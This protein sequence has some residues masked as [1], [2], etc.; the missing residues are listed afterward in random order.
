MRNVPVGAGYVA[1]KTKAL[2]PL[3]IIM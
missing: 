2:V 1:A 3:I